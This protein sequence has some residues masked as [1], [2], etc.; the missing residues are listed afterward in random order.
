M[1]RKKFNNNSIN[2]KNQKKEKKRKSAT[3]VNAGLKVVAPLSYL[4]CASHIVCYMEREGREREKKKRK[5]G[6]SNI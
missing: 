6:M 4:E 3:C 1:V 5:S 2:Q